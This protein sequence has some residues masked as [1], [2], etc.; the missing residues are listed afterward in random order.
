PAGVS[1]A[2]DEAFRPDAGDSQGRGGRLRTNP[3]RTSAAPGAVPAHRPR[4]AALR[5]AQPARP[6][7]VPAADPATADP[8][9]VRAVRAAVA[10]GGDAARD[11]VRRGRRV[12]VRAH[13]VPGGHRT[14]TGVRA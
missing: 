1:R 11:G 5:I 14:G 3:A 8:A 6:V 9:T 7:A 13:D 2:D 4:T 10:G 12:A